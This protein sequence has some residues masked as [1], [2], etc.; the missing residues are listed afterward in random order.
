MSTLLCNKVTPEGQPV[1][2]NKRELLMRK[3]SM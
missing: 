3:E 1:L 2:G